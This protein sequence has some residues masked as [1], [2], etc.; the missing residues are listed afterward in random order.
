MLKFDE[1]FSGIATDNLGRVSG[2]HFFHHT[3]FSIFVAH[4]IDPTEQKAAS[5][6][7]GTK[8][9]IGIYSN[10]V[11]DGKQDQQYEKPTSE[12]P[13]ILRFQAFK[14]KAFIDALVDMIYTVCHGWMFFA[15]KVK[16][17]KT[18]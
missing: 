12:I 16:A 5:Q 7:N 4:F 17:R 14:F 15:V 6:Q 11:H 3:V 10:D 18:I 2:C 8:T 9:E 13:D 1:V